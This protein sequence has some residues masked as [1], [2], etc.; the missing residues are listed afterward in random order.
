M[1]PSTISVIIA[2]AS[3]AQRGWIIAFPAGFG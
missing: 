2:S 1:T 3:N